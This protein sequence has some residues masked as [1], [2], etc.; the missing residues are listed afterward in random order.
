MTNLGPKT[1]LL[2]LEPCVLL[3]FQKSETMEKLLYLGSKS[4]P[5]PFKRA[6]VE[7]LKQVE[8]KT[9]KLF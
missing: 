7:P 6:E 8:L 3:F 5:Q 1:F 9:S 4:S 2:I